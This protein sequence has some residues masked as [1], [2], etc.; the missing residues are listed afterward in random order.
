[1]F[2]SRKQLNV[3]EKE[4]IERDRFFFVS[5]VVAWL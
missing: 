4:K 3:R 1:M 5:F 2:A